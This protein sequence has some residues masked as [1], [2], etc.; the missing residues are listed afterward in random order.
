MECSLGT[1]AVF[2]L[3]GQCFIIFSFLS[4]RIQ[5]EDVFGTSVVHVAQPPL[6]Q[7]AYQKVAVPFSVGLHKAQ[8]ASFKGESAVKMFWLPPPFPPY[9]FSTTS[10]W[11]DFINFN[12]IF[13]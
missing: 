11:T 9:Y 3:W 7:V 12:N 10:A 13:I 4:G 5:G 2:C 1:L 6:A 8:D